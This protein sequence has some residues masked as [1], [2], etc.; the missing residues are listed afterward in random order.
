MIFINP[1]LQEF[2]FP[3]IVE[4]QPKIG[5]NRDIR[6]F[7]MIPVYFTIEILVMLFIKDYMQ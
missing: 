2:G 1:L 3:S 7:S 6:I 5:S 4:I